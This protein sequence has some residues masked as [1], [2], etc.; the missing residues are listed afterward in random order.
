MVQL[1]I[2]ER[3]YNENNLLY[4]QTAMSEMFTYAGCRARM[5]SFGGRTRLIIST[6]ECYSDIIKAEIADKI[7]EIIAIKYKYD[8]LKE[9]VCIGGL[10]TLEK[11]IL[12]ASL[13]AADL[14]D[15]KKYSFN[16]IKE[17]SEIAI[18]G[19]YNFRLKPL[20]KK[21]QD[22]ASY[23]PTCFL[24]TQLKEFVTYLLENKKKRVYVEGGIVY[25]S[26]FRRLR[27]SSLLGGEGVEIL[28]EVLLSGCGEVELSGEVPKDD[29]FYLRE[30][31]S[32][33][34]HFST[35]F[36]DGDKYLN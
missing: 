22:V 15:D 36:V 3:Q 31:Y 18:D 10:K 16:K 6:S 8:F 24:N 12:L 29:E 32:D 30:Y 26:H 19:V 4:V 7:A 14:D 13:I 33:K 11:E 20:K 28:R 17:F 27:R 5:Q 34:I 2:T 23:I 21:W 25:D 35:S 9:N 1:T